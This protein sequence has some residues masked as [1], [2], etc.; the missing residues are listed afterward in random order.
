MF[1][2][3]HPGSRDMTIFGEWTS[4]KEPKFDKNAHNFDTR[5]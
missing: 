1:R 5:V 2:N 4:L 3:L